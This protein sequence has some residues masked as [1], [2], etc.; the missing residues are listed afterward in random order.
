MCIN[1]IQISNIIFFQPDCDIRLSGH[2]SWVG[3]SSIEITVWLEQELSG[4]WHMLTRAVFLMA[5]RE[6]TGHGPAIVNTLLPVTEK[7]KER[8]EK[9]ESKSHYFNQ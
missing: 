9:G 3:R 6:P 7:E 1:I 5:A 8:Y 2:V 4:S